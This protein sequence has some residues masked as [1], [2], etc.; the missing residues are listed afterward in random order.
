MKS[1][2]SILNPPISSAGRVKRKLDEV[3]L[4]SWEPR[5][6]GEVHP[7]VED[8]A[9]GEKRVA[10]Q[11]AKEQAKTKVEDLR[12][13][14]PVILVDDKVDKQGLSRFVGDPI[15]AVV[16]DPN[17][18]NPNQHG[19][20]I[21][22]LRRSERAA[23]PMSKE[24]LNEFKTLHGSTVHGRG[25]IG[26]MGDL[27]T[28]RDTLL[29][30]IYSSVPTNAKT[31]HP[32]NE[33]PRFID[34]A[35]SDLLKKGLKG[36]W[37]TTREIVASQQ[38]GKGLADFRGRVISP[39]DEWN[40]LQ[41]EGRASMVKS[42]DPGLER[43]KTTPAVEGTRLKATHGKKEEFALL[44]QRGYDLIMSLRQKVQRERKPFTT[45]VLSLDLDINQLRNEIKSEQDV[46]KRATLMRVFEGLIAD[47]RALYQKINTRTH[48][49]DELAR[50][51]MTYRK[52]FGEIG[53]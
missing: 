24:G 34:A 5:H 36:D 48:T 38:S 23:T 8:D 11:R 37:E 32:V 21:P 14:V 45:Q 29:E 26:T 6:E 51:E 12:F 40:R 42:S 25:N 16:T 33:D 22:I 13:D 47:R 28:S 2:E 30:A 50:A 52:T 44:Q 18:V 53:E 4:D 43:Y 17:L 9:A 3:L 46:K 20:G 7:L 49:E 10:A 19:A 15:P 41:R 27:D 1:L 35:G 39:D 31:I